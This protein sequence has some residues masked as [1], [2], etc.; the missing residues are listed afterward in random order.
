MKFF[1][2]ERCVGWLAIVGLALTWAVVIGI[3]VFVYLHVS[4]QKHAE[5]YFG[6]TIS[7]DFSEEKKILLRPL[8]EGRIRAMAEIYA[9]A[10]A[11]GAGFKEQKNSRRSDLYRACAAAKYFELIDDDYIWCR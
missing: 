1:K 11:A 8:V 4:Y 2:Q 9:E 10:A 3:M 5:E 6:V 7:R